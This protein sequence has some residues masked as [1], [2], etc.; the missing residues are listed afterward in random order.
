M[1]TTE[2]S[3]EIHK[4]QQLKNG[5]TAVDLTALVKQI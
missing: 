5:Y 3:K 4:T 2:I 1:K